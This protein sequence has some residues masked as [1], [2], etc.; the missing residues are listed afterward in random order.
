MAAVTKGTAHVYGVQGSVTGG[1]VQSFSRKKSFQNTASTVDEDGNEIERR[2]DDLLTEATIELK[3]K[4][5]GY[6]DIAPGATLTYDSVA[7]EV[8]S[9]DRKEEAK[10][11]TIVTLTVKTS[12]YVSLA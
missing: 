4:T 9:N 10:G 11:H 12:E 2:S 6:T 8:I 7:Y 5:S 1:T 3:I